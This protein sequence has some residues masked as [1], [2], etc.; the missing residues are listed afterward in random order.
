MRGEPVPPMPVRRPLSAQRP[1]RKNEIAEQ[2][3]HLRRGLGPT[4]GAL[5]T[6]PRSG[7]KS[8]ARFLGAEARNLCDLTNSAISALIKMLHRPHHEIQPAALPARQP[9]QAGIVNRPPAPGRATSPPRSTGQNHCAAA[10]AS[11]RKSEPALASQATTGFRFVHRNGFANVALK[12][13]VQPGR[14]FR[15]G[16][17]ANPGEQWSRL[18]P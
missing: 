4:V 2:I 18:I 1:Q 8:S 3:S 5:G 10:R 14:Q 11:R 15:R 7:A 6:K 17:L 13:P 12:V 16:V 9:M